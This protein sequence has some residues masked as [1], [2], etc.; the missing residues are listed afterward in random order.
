MFAYL[1]INSFLHRRNPIIKLIVIA[2]IAVIVCVSYFPILPAGTFLLAFFTIWL[3]GNIPL[4]ELVRRLSLFI[5]VSFFFMISILLLRGL[6]SEEGVILKVGIFQWTEKDFIHGITLGFRILSLVTMSL[7]FVLTTKPID[8]VLSLM[9]QCGVPV[10]HG[11]ATMATYRF[12]P[13]L[14]QQV[15]TIHLAQEIRGIPWKKGIISRFTSPFRVA[16]PL[17]CLA[18][19][20]GERIACAMESR[21]LGR[22]QKR[23]YYK[24]VG[25][26]KKDYFF[27][28]ISILVYMIFI[29]ILIKYDLFHYNFAAI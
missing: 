14:Q 11:Y 28:G 5:C 4:S 18:A 16:L 13:E 23:S 15:D 22:N 20:R 7:G 17:F 10:V 12:L 19:R 24:K 2:F 1:D 27:L 8:L 9:M 25:V 3:G 6:N 21:G 26:D 29:F